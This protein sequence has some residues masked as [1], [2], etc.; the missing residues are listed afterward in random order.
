MKCT[1]EDHDLY[2]YYGMAPHDH[3]ISKT[4]SFIGST[5]TKH[6]KDWPH[7]FSPDPETDGG[8]GIWSCPDCTPKP[9]G[10]T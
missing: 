1:N 7:N 10:T 6:K 9:E 2:P 4:G 5:V 8:R 3:D